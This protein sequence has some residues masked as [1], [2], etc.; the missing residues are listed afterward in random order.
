MHLSNTPIGPPR[1]PL[2]PSNTQ[3][4]HKADKIKARRELKGASTSI[5]SGAPGSGAGVGI[6]SSAG[7]PAGTK[8]SSLAHNYGAAMGIDD[9]GA[10]VGI[11]GDSGRKTRSL[12]SGLGPGEVVGAPTSGTG[13]SGSGGGGGVV[14]GG[15]GKAVL[16]SFRNAMS[17]TRPPGKPDVAKQQQQQQQTAVNEGSV[18]DH[19]L[20]RVYQHTGPGPS[21]RSMRPVPM[22]VPVRSLSAS[23]KKNQPTVRNAGQ[24]RGAGEGVAGGR[25]GAHNPLD[26]KGLQ[27]SVGAVAGVSGRRRTFDTSIGS[28]P[29]AHPDHLERVV[30][31]S[32]GTSSSN[33]S[34]VTTRAGARADVAGYVGYGEAAA[35][36]AAA[37]HSTSDALL[38]PT[39]LAAGRLPAVVPGP[40]PRV[41]RR[42]RDRNS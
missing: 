32:L 23:N 28:F 40:G 17:L 12:V 2:P 29:V 5:G 14:G 33:G 30:P 18:L 26:S 27:G 10:G 11:G 25:L 31:L 9:S 38:V 13:A 42:Q 4:M 34:G 37:I 8:L 39:G 36:A 22:P 35:A 7:V 16:S 21:H 19:G 24:E 15:L 3:I 1:G 6:S 20:R 41:G